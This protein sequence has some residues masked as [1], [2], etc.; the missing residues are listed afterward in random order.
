[1]MFV[2]L[3]CDLILFTVTFFLVTIFLLHSEN[4]HVSAILQ[5][6][7]ILKRILYVLI[8]TDI[9]NLG[10]HFYIF[11]VA[12]PSIGTLTGILCPAS[13]TVLK[14]PVQSF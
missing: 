13:K 14:S 3:S 8:K 2:Y 9:G 1:M 12:Y 11:V 5:Q 4:Y 10:L 6:N 7:E